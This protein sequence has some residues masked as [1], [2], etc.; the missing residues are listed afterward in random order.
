MSGSIGKALG[1]LLI[2]ELATLQVCNL[3]KNLFGIGRDLTSES[4]EQSFCWV[5]VIN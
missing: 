2:L 3:E 5:R 1:G 4:F